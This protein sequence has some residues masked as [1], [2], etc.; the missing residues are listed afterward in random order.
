M[1]KLKNLKLAIVLIGLLLVA[2]TMFLFQKPFYP[3][4]FSEYRS[5]WVGV[6]LQKIQDEL[7]VKEKQFPNLKK[8]CEKRIGFAADKVR[9]NTSLIYVPGFTATRREIF[10]VVES[11][12]KK[13]SANYFLTRF[14]AHGESA[15]DFK[16]YRPQG[17]FDTLY[18]AS[19]IGSKLGKKKIFI[20]LST[21]AALISAGLIQ[22]MDIDAAILIAPAFSVYPKSSWLLSTRMGQIFNWTLSDEIRK[23]T[24]KNPVME[25][26]WNT[27]YH[28]DAVKA[29]L[30]TLEYIKG[31]DF[32]KIKVPVMVLYT[33]NDDVVINKA[34][35]E[36][37]AEIKDS[38]KRLV[39]I[40][41]SHHVLA[42]EYTSPETTE[43]VI[44]DIHDWLQ[45]LNLAL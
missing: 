8:D 3:A 40:P 29:L 32:S 11:L 17:F 44:K 13:L 43:L 7:Q 23:W 39:E 12:A 18:E 14:P 2:V 6:S 20:G 31:L 42:G 9:S 22:G 38:R 27:S 21:G 28:R 25:N 15:I 36:K 30:E 24:P 5:R 10:P 19:D 45:N 41:S 1:K 35:L 37:F 33:P 16:G 26:Y 34:I 4:M